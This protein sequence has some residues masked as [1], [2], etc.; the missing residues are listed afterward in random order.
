MEMLGRSTKG[1]FQPNMLHLPTKGIFGG[2]FDL[3]HVTIDFIL[4]I[5]RILD[6]TLDMTTELNRDLDM[7][8]S[9]NRTLYMTKTLNRTLNITRQLDREVT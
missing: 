8:M 9:I 5:T 6:R 7:S 3:S 1:L 2:I 4:S